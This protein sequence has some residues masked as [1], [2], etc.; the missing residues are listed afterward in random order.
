MEEGCSSLKNRHRRKIQWLLSYS[1]YVSHKALFYNEATRQ[2]TIA[3]G[4]DMNT[5]P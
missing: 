2:W 1:A 3:A 5:E 4:T